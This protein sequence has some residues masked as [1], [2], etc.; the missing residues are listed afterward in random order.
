MKRV[1][2]S[3]LRKLYTFVMGERVP[4][5]KIDPPSFKTVIPEPLLS[6]NDWGL[7]CNTSSRV[8]R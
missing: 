5:Y 1:S 4:G 7:H 6:Y 2:D 8:P 3:L